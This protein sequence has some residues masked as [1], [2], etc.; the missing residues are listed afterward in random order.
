MTCPKG[1]IQATG[2]AGGYDLPI[3]ILTVDLGT[4]SYKILD[5]LRGLWQNILCIGIFPLFKK[6]IHYE[7]EL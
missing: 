1:A 2:T 3:L 5:F 4:N 6:G 7:Q